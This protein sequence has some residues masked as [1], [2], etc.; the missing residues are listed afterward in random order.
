MS[1]SFPY[2]Q[3]HV[4]KWTGGK[5]SFFGFKEQGLFLYLCNQAWMN[6]GKFTICH[7]LV[8]QKASGGEGWLEET[9]E[10]FKSC[11]ILIQEDDGGY[12][13][14]FIDK[15]LA[16]MNEIRVK[17]SSAAKSGIE[18]RIKNKKEKKSKGKVKKHM[19]DDAEQMLSKCSANAEPA[20]GGFKTW[21]V[22][23]FRHECSVANSDGL[24]KQEEL[25]DFIGYWLEPNN[26]GR[27]R[28]Q[29]QETWETKRR[30]STAK[31]MIFSKQDKTSN[32][33]YFGM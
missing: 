5:I 9:I 3:F 8:Q 13:I 22:E 16:Y 26:A 29:L 18:L 6:G 20:I 2:W 33:T 21:T 24:L 27:P 17:R 31:K 1:N 10:S 23:Q 12:R 15:Q 14:K 19:L 4:E 11:G 30:M 7:A 28:F 32:I 25:K